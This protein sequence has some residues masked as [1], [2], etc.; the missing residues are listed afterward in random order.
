MFCRVLIHLLF[1]IIK[2]TRLQSLTR[3]FYDTQLVNKNQACTVS[4][5]IHYS[6]I[7]PKQ[8]T[9]SDLL[10]TLSGLRC[11]LNLYW[12]LYVQ[13]IWWMYTQGSHS[14]RKS[15]NLKF[16]F[17][18]WES[19]MEFIQENSQIFISLVSTLWLPNTVSNIFETFFGDHQN[20]QPKELVVFTCSQCSRSWNQNFMSMFLCE[21]WWIRGFYE[22]SFVKL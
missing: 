2:L 10:R 18:A 13:K 7:A 3:L 1:H 9:N 22:V 8:I 21:P 20:L 17:Q 6:I 19:R 11:T 12:V 14:H 4:T 16:G 5:N 15:C